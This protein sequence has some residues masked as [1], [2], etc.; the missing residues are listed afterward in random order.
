MG[1]G[2]S[3]GKFCR[4]NC[5]CGAMSVFANTRGCVS[6]WLP[7]LPRVQ[8][9]LAL[10]RKNFPASTKAS[11][12][13]T[14]HDDRRPASST[15]DR[16]QGA[17]AGQCARHEQDRHRGCISLFPASPF[18]VKIPGLPR[19]R[20]GALG[21]RPTGVWVVLRLS[22]VLRVWAAHALAAATHGGHRR[23]EPA[24]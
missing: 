14:A 22:F 19:T 1:L 16:A 6:P 21:R 24:R 15:R 18:A 5:T 17:A 2:R 3:T 10:V 9:I 12:R 4:V 7:P 20:R 11:P 8:Q 23:G 13:P